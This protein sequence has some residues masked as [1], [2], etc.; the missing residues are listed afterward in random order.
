[1]DDLFK[2]SV[3]EALIF[4]VRTEIEDLGLSD[5][6]TALYMP[7]HGA[8]RLRWSDGEEVLEVPATAES[9]ERLRAYL[10]AYARAKQ[11]NR[12]A[13]ASPHGQ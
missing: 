8:V 5:S 10:Q 11:R 3:G 4:E 13:P 9:V 6:V 2:D 12:S 1:M 7:P